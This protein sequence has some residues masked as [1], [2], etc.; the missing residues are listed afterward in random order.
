MIEFALLF[1]YL[2]LGHGV[3][4]D[5]NCST[6]RHIIDKLVEKFNVPTIWVHVDPPE[7]FIVKKLKNFKHTFL[8]K[9]G[10]QAVYTYF[11]D[12]ISLENFDRPFLY[13]FDT[14]K[15]TLISQI[16]EA[17]NLILKYLKG[18]AGDM[19]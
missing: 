11:K 12:K 17:S 14:S 19:R 18:L 5:T 13:I 9:D 8:F 4:Y 1:K 7:E 10:E 2:S 3:A 15:D 6:K 16:S